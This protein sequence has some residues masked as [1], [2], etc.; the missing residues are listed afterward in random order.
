M[1]IINILTPFVV[2]ATLSSCTVTRAEFDSWHT[3]LEGSPK[4]RAEWIA[5]CSKK[6]RT[7]EWISD[8][9]DWMNVPKSSAKST[10]C[11]R[12]YGALASGRLTYRDAQSIAEPPLTP[13][14]I[15]IMQGR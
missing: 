15:R 4:I 10:F 14:L 2:A 9:S 13:N 3:L 1:K 11:N 6:P 7:A 12:M 5:D 8:M